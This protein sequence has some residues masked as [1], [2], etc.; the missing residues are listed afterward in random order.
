MFESFRKSNSSLKY[1]QEYPTIFFKSSP[2]TGKTGLCEL[3]ERAFVEA[4]SHVQVFRFNCAGW[5][6]GGF[7]TSAFILQRTNGLVD[8]RLEKFN[9]TVP[10]L[11]IMDDIF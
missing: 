2:A 8:L 6:E 9:G 10:T 7:T 11:V 3:V 1:V 4:N 5:E